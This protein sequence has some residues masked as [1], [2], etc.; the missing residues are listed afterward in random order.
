MLLFA[1][2]MLAMAVDATQRSFEKEGQVA[3]PPTP[4]GP[5]AVALQQQVNTAVA[6]HAAVIAVAGGKY[7]FNGADFEVFDAFNLRFVATTPVLLS[8]APGFGVHFRSSSNVSVVDWTID[9]DPPWTKRTFGV[10]YQLTNCSDILTEDLT[11]LSAPQMAVTGYNGGGGHIFRRLQ[12]TRSPHAAPGTFPLVSSQDAVHFSDL[13]RGPTV[14]DSNIGFSGDD[15]FNVHSTLMMVLTCASKTSCV[16]MNTGCE[17]PG[18]LERPVCLK[19]RKLCYGSRTPPLLDATFVSAD[20]RSSGDVIA[21]E[22]PA[23]LRT[24]PW[25]RLGQ[26]IT[27]ASLV[28]Q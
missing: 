18:S 21:F 23:T 6:A 13:R 8:F 4:A 20:V 10:T 19:S 27:S 5:R 1:A 22:G 15:F 3:T 12:F 14:E 11:I 9:Y 7:Q 17:L 25:Q 16:L 28:G 24:V 2:I 26:G